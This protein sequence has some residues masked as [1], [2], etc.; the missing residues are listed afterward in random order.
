MQP[1]GDASDRR[2]TGDRREHG[3]HDER[4]GAK[5]GTSALAY[6]LRSLAAV[7][8]LVGV[9]LYALSVTR[10]I[11]ATRGTLGEELRK[12]APEVAGSIAG[13][14]TAGGQLMATPEVQGGKGDFYE[15]G[16]GL[17]QGGAARA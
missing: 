14:S 4:R 7:V 3:A 16:M 10:P 15:G 13:D 1:G 9:I 2:S 12:H 5:R 17:K 6:V 11:Y 8:V